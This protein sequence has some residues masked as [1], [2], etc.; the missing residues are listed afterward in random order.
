MAAQAL[1][2]R[3]RLTGDYAAA[4]ERGLAAWQR[5]RDAWTGASNPC[6]LRDRAPGRL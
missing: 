4:G 3:L 2:H 6:C 5:R 1:A